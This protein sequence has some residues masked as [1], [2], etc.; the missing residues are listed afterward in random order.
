M[1]FGVL[2]HR[3]ITALGDLPLGVKFNRV[4]DARAQSGRAGTRCGLP[5]AGRLDSMRGLG[6]GGSATPAAAGDLGGPA[7]GDTNHELL[8]VRERA[9]MARFLSNR[10]NH[11]SSPARQH[12]KGGG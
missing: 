5:Y 8:A 3:G 7:V 9:S 10:S 2:H 11:R 6:V 1:S 4:A 12:D